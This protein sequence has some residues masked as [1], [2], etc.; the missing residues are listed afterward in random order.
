MSR[1]WA[2]TDGHG[3]KLTDGRVCLVIEP[4]DP[5]LPT[6]RT[7][8]HDKDEVL[9]KVAHMAETGQ[10]TITRLRTAQPSTQVSPASPA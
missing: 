3:N 10:A 6:I 5:S 4:D 1:Y 9:D 7:Y 8:G 2:D